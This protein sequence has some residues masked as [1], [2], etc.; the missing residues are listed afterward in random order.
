MAVDRQSA[1]FEVAPYFDD[2]LDRLESGD[3]VSEAAFGRHVHWGY[4]PAPA[5]ADGS[6]A[7]Y[8]AAAERLC[9]LLCDAADIRNGMNVLDVGCGF[10]GT[11]AS[12]NERF[13]ALKM[14]GV[15]I[16]PRQLA[17]ARAKVAPRAGNDVRFV[18]GDACNLAFA[19]ATFDRILAVECIFHFD[20]RV[21][22]LRG[23]A[24]VLK[25][26]GRLTLS[27]FVPAGATLAQLQQHDPGRDDA[28]RA[29]YGKVDVQTTLERYR[30]LG[31]A[32][33]LTLLESRNITAN[34]LPTY[35]FLQADFRRHPNRKAARVH[36]KATS[37]LEIACQLDLLHYTILTFGRG[38][39]AA[40]Q[41]A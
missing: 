29:T 33:G 34:T 30:E 28:T 1:P 4:W 27:D 8:A 15:N 13:A 10:G 31:A 16:D 18:E 7:D 17:R 9:R 14:V 5:L 11:I 36:S 24:K 40:A 23:A 21:D 2:L 35:D 26:G 6:P 12:L 32:V 3:P 20:S 38:A 41:A 25:P 37:R 19:E 22:F 39:D